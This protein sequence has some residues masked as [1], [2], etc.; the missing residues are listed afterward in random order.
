MTDENIKERIISSAQERFF[1]LGF[2]KVTMDELVSQ[3]GISKKTMYKFFASKDELVQ[4]ITEWQM[5]HVASKV[6]EIVNS[7]TDFI[8]KMHNLWTFMGEMYSRMSKQYHDDMRRFRPDL[9]K[10]IEE[11]RHENLIENATKLIDDGIKLGVFRADVNK[12]I[13]VLMYVSAVHGIINPDVLISH[14]FSAEEAFKTILRV[15]FDGIL[16]DQARQY[17]RSR[18]TN[19]KQK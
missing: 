14:P 8:E 3:L 4:A 16:T 9:W 18:F 10:R 1:A 2:S 12:E 19:E 7:P 13:L 17:Y 11:F 15:I 6:K 5:I